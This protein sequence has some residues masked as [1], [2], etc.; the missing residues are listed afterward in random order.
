MNRRVSTPRI[1]DS[2]GL[3]LLLDDAMQVIELLSVVPLDAI[4]TMAGIRRVVRRVTKHPIVI[5]Q[6][7]CAAMLKTARTPEQILFLCNHS[8]PL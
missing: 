6:H 8:K 5:A 2:D 7:Y 4:S 3:E 1:D